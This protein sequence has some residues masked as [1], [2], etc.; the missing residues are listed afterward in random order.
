MERMLVGAL[1]SFLAIFILDKQKK[2]TVPRYTL[3]CN[4][5][6]DLTRRSETV[7]THITSLLTQKEIEIQWTDKP[8]TPWGGM[9]LFSGVVQQVGLI[10][11]LRE[12]LPFRLTS[13]NA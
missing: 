8:V 13:P 9:M 10:S 12:A 3:R 1:F 11:A 2:N 5:I 7:L 6:K 4:Q